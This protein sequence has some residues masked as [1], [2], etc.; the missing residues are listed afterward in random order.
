[1]DGIWIPTRMGRPESDCE[2]DIRYGR[3]DRV[4]EKRAWYIEGDF[5]NTE[6]KR[7][8]DV[9]HWRKTRATKRN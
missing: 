8:K 2:C 7:V 3:G 4:E 9:T 1:M 6:G 5:C